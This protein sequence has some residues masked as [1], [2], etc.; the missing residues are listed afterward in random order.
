[1]EVSV[2]APT[3]VAQVDMNK[4]VAQFIKLRDKIKEIEDRHAEELAPYREAMEQLEGLFLEHLNNTGS[5]KVGTE[6]GTVYRTE[7][8]SASLADRTA[9]WAYVVSQAD[10]D[11]LDYK[12][13]PTQV[14]AFIE[15]HGSPPPG[16]NFQVRHTV[17]VR[18]K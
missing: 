8:K 3:T 15:K 11:L 4:R 14:A 18:R 9:F 16:V 1:M 10:W 5:D 7:K 6:A 2:N 17:G 12:A 13:N